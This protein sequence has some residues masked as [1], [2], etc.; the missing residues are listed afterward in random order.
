MVVLGW[1]PADTHTNNFWTELASGAG[2]G[3][4]F[5]VTFTAKKYLWL[6]FYGNL[7]SGTGGLALR[8]GSGS[9]DTGTNYSRRIA[10]N[11][12]GDGTQLSDDNINPAY[13]DNPNNFFLNMFIVNVSGKEKL[14]ISHLVDQSTA[15]AGTAPN[16]YENVSKYTTTSGQIDRFRFL[17]AGGGTWSSTTKATIWGAD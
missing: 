12:G 7:S 6:Q 2:S 16:V 14:F 8:T 10:K 13:P 3:T 1:D 5:D 9:V 17:T 4:S 15:G 11:F